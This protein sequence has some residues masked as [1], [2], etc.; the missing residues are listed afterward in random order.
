MARPNAAQMKKNGTK[1]I[2]EPVH[3][4]PP[5]T[6]TAGEAEDCMMAGETVA[7]AGIDALARTA[8]A[9]GAPAGPDLDWS[10]A[11]LAGVA[12]ATDNDGPVVGPAA[13]SGLTGIGPEHEMTTNETPTASSVAKPDTLDMMFPLRFGGWSGEIMPNSRAGFKKNMSY[14]QEMGN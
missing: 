14:R 6:A 2:D 5:A 10:R 1:K 3:G 9:A 4:D 12:L 8:G 11:V 7:A 13:T